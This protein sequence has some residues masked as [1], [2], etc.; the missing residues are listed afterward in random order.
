MREIL[1]RAK[2][3]D[4]NEYVYWDKFGKLI[5][6]FKDGTVIFKAGIHICTV[7]LTKKRV[8]LD[9]TAQYIGLT[10]KNDR[11]IYE[12]DIIKVHDLSTGYTNYKL[13][14]VEYD[15]NSCAYEFY[16]WSGDIH[17][18]EI[19]GNIYETPN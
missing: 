13:K 18:V 11:W 3:L 17:S 12:G 6:D 16:R 5:D 9:T 14:T 7:N 4:S 8:N 1:F 10:D 15:S 19:I 2:I